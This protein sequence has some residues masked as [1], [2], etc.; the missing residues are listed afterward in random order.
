MEAARPAATV[1]L[2]MP[3]FNERSRLA[4]DEICSLTSDER[5]SLVMVDDGSTDGT[6][7]LLRALERDSHDISV[8]ALPANVGKGEAV[9]AGLT[10]ALAA[11]PTWVGYVD[12]DMS[13]PAS[14]VLRLLD[15]AQAT[16]RFDVVFG[17]RVA[18]LGRHVQRSSFRHY[19]GRVFATLASL[20]LSKAVYDTQCGAKLFR[21]TEALHRSISVPF[22]SRWAFDVELL[23]RLHAA[24]IDPS[25][26]WEEPLQVWRDADGSRRSVAASVRATASLLSIWRDLRASRR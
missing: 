5:V 17:A 7:E 19:A 1:H 12:A 10:S 20:V 6:L 26:F 13:T 3:C 2:V 16:D 18:M 8:I 11:K 15:L 23:G 21:R 9:R 14:E 22:R 24:G 25:R 4:V